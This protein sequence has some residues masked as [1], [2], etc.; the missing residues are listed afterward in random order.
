MASESVKIPD[1]KG[2][3]FIS[4]P[5][6]SE[7]LRCVKCGYVTSYAQTR[8]IPALRRIAECRRDA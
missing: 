8:V 4:D 3:D 7:R 6:F 1:H 5:P 2:H